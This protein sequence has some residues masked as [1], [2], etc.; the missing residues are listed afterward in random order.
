MAGMFTAILVTLPPVVFLIILFGGG[1][2]SLRKHIDQDGNSPI[3]RT[4]FYTSKWSVVILWIAMILQVWGIS[5]SLVEVPT[6]LTW[7]S[8]FLW[9]FGFAFLYY[10][11]FKLGS[12]FRLGTPKERTSF[13]TDGLYGFSRNPM[14]LGLYSTI[15][16]SMLY[17]LNPVVILLGIFIIAVHHKIVLGEEEFMRKE[18]GQEYLDYS[19]RVRRYI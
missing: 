16:A 2:L 15:L 10:G 11:R 5:I 13:M 9:F 8:M 14:Y 19:H 4:L 18:F 12:S 6:G 17:T 1:F 3:N 7:V